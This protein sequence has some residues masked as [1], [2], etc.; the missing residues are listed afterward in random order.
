MKLLFLLSPVL[1]IL[2]C[3]PRGL[4]SEG[5]KEAYE[6]PRAVI[7]DEDTR[8]DILNPEALTSPAQATALLFHIESLQPQRDGRFWVPP[9]PLRIHFPLCENERFL[10]QDTL[11]YCTGVLIGP[12]SVLTA[13][14]CVPDEKGCE[15]TSLT[16]AR[17]EERAQTGILE[18]G[19]I[20]SCKRILKSGKLPMKDFAVL[21]LDREVTQSK[22]VSLGRASLMKAKD[23]VWSFSYPLGLPLKKDRGEILKNDSLNFYLRAKVDTFSG[24]SGS[25]LFNDRNELIGI[26]A[27]GT[28]DFD[29]TAEELRKKFI[30]GHC[31]H[32]RRCQEGFCFGERYLKIDTMDLGI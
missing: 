20:Y 30:E 14:H 25:P 7:W 2:S 18:A 26:L 13:S 5:R 17:T 32:P 8:E 23:P 12:R 11:G 16:F 10:D 24:S 31:V 27:S 6:K 3:T 22:P 9:N 15:K 29:L 4:P 28:D 19:D 1:W 21:E